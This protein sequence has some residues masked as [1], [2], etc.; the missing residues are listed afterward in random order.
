[1]EENIDGIN[2]I[3]GMLVQMPRFIDILVISKND[4]E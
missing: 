1:M 2:K 4:K 3:G